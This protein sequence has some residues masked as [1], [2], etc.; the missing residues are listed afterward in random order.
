VLTR[1][2]Y[3]PFTGNTY[4]NPSDLDI[5]HLVPLK[6]AHISGAHLWTATRR[7]QY[8]NDLSD[9]D[10][11]IAVSNSANRSKGAKDVAQWLPTNEAF[12]CEYVKRWVGVKDRWGLNLDRVEADAVE[13]LLL[14]C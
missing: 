10:S 14:E 6:E 3:D 8:A 7:E 13:T 12:H 11:L 4:T 9:P 5:D 1:N 2:R